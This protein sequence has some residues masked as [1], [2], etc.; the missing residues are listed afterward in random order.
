M[1]KQRQIEMEGCFNEVCY[2]CGA[3]IAESTAVT[4]IGGAM[5]IYLCAFCCGAEFIFDDLGYLAFS[6]PTH[7]T[8][9]IAGMIRYWNALDKFNEK[10][11]EAESKTKRGPRIKRGVNWETELEKLRE[12]YRCIA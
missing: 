3:D 9:D 1:K 11:R 4:S 12:A 6:C 8:E 5:R 10:A 7:G 2:C